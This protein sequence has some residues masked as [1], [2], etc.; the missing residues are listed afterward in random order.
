VFVNR[1]QLSGMSNTTIWI[2]ARKRESSPDNM[3]LQRELD[4]MEGISI[5]S[6][7]RD[8][9][10]IEATPEG[11]QRVRERLSASF[12]IEP[13]APRSELS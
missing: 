10:Q 2:L 11:I 4:S 6:A 9:G 13:A 12:H 1:G 7:T 3:D 8:R 5:V